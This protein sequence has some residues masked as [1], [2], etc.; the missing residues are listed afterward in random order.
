MRGVEVT[1]SAAMHRVK[2]YGRRLLEQGKQ[3]S[4]ITYY[5]SLVKYF[6]SDRS[7][8][9]V[10]M[11]LH[12]YI[13]IGAAFEELGMHTTAMEYY[14]KGMDLAKPEK[15]APYRAMLLNNI[16]VLY[17]DAKML[18]KA[19]EYFKQSAAINQKKFNRQE[20]FINY[21]N[22]SYTREQLGAIDQALDYSL[23]ALSYVNPERQPEEYN[24]MQVTLGVLYTK[25]GDYPVAISYL[26][27]AIQDLEKSKYIPTLIEGC[28]ALSEAYLKTGDYA[29]AEFYN[30]KAIDAAAKSELDKTLWEGY[31]QRSRIAR[32]KGLF[33]QAYDA[34]NKASELKDS[35]QNEQNRRRMQEWEEVY[36][37]L[38]SQEAPRQQ[39]APWLWILL[40]LSII[41]VGSA[42]LLLILLRKAKKRPSPS[43]LADSK[44]I[45]EKTEEIDK[46]NRELA[47]YSLEKMSTAESFASVETELRKII[48]ELGPRDKENRLRT[49]SLLNQFTG[50]LQPGAAW[51]EFEYY[52]MQVHSEF[53]RK[54]NE[55]FPDLTVK[56]KRLCAFLYLELTTKEIAT[57]TSRE[58]RSVESSRLRLRKKLGLDPD[59]DLTHFLQSL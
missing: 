41:G 7:E 1:D 12:S 49:Q 13:C 29:K 46:L 40:P 48:S 57:F 23:K 26:T 39:S 20:L 38:Y 55:R 44:Q 15:F 54:L 25:K 5:T 10:K 30:Q 18:D 56:E 2:Q 22:L 31:E 17:C 16:G 8:P 34:L 58:V 47:R 4:A 42:I 19:E 3:A 6:N 9:N 24:S 50:M 28:S 27:K 32:A 52:F 21:T 59:S 43:A 53:Y 36:K 35:I 45:E 14:M 37:T 11:L 33:P 51:Q